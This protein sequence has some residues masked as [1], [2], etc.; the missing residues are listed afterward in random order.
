M[1]K[2]LNSSVN[3]NMAFT[4]DS[5]QAK[6]QIQEL[7]MA[8]HGLVNNTKLD[9]GLDDQIQ[10]AISATAELSAHLQKATNTKTGTLDFSK[11]SQSIKT[12][13]KSLSEYG[14]QLQRLGPQGQQAFMQLTQSIVQ[15]EVPLK[16]VNAKV[17]EFA[18]TLANT[19][20]WQLSSSV[21]H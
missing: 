14:Q 12:S 6:R 17:Q 2:R 21:L 13:G 9:L 18:N 10:S 19:A 4:A 5:S 11:L 7:Q 20:R 16:R 3:V 15:A 1:A 8:L